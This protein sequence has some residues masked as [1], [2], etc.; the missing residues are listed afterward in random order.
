MVRGAQPAK[1]SAIDTEGGEDDIN[2]K[3][4]DDDEVQGYTTSDH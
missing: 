4:D 1:Q 2:N 3:E